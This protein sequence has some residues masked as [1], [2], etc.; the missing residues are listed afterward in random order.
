M[1][2]GILICPAAQL[3]SRKFDLW[4]RL[5]SILQQQQF[6]WQLDDDTTASNLRYSAD[7]IEIKINYCGQSR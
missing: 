6:H 4:Q 2:G 3:L 1:N 7:A 5:L